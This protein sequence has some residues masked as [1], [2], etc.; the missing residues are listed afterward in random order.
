MA[1]SCRKVILALTK[2]NW[3]NCGF[4]SGSPITT[5]LSKQVAKILTELPAGQPGETKYRFFM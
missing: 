2:L 4:A 1:W 3:K 5:A